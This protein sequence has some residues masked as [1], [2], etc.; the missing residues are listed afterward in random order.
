MKWE[1]MEQNNT[2]FGNSG[3]QWSDP[4]QGI[5]YN[6][7]LVSAFSSLATNPDIIKNIFLSK[8][9]GRDKGLYSISL[10]KNGI[11]S[12]VIIDDFLPSIDKKLQLCNSNEENASLWP[13]LME[14]A[15]AKLYGCYSSIGIEGA[16]GNAFNDF[17]GAPY[18]EHELNSMQESD[19]SEV[20]EKA[21]RKKNLVTVMDSESLLHFSAIKIES[22]KLTLR[23]PKGASG[24]FPE[25]LEGNEKGVVEVNLEQLKELFE[26]ITVV[27]YRPDSVIS[28]MPIPKEE[29]CTEKISTFQL[30]PEASGSYFV[31]W[32]RVDGRCLIG[33]KSSVNL[34][35][36]SEGI[37]SEKEMSSIAVVKQGDK[38]IFLKGNACHQRDNSVEL[39]LEAGEKYIVYVKKI[40]LNFFKIF[41]IILKFFNRLDV[42][43]PGI[44]IKKNST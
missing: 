24:E 3:P 37:L 12:E 26:S 2:L 16:P 32:H 34:F 44:K 19:I 29:A 28:A 41:Q 30:E 22:K 13:M 17:T 14:K 9:E 15:Y 40:F 25:G 36:V 8:E 33:H 6:S 5:L 1:K 23:H 31:S 42:W 10:R 21:S 38:P 39:E 11:F 35:G 43:I 20:L 18:I 7:Y 4:I 27:H